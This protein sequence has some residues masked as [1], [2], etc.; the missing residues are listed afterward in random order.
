[1]P[2]GGVAGG[3]YD[4]GAS[5]PRRS[6]LSFSPVDKSSESLSI[7]SVNSED[8]EDFINRTSRQVN[9]FFR[10]VDQDDAVKCQRFPDS[11]ER[12]EAVGVANFFGE[13]EHVSDWKSFADLEKLEKQSPK[14]TKTGGAET[15]AFYLPPVRTGKSKKVIEA[16]YQKARIPETEV[17]QKKKLSRG[18]TFSGKVPESPKTPVIST[19]LALS[20]SDLLQLEAMANSSQVSHIHTRTKKTKKVDEQSSSRKKLPRGVTF[21]GKLPTSSKIGHPDLVAETPDPNGMAS[22]KPQSMRGKGSVPFYQKM[23]KYDKSADINDESGKKEFV[24]RSLPRVKTFDGTNKVIEMPITKESSTQ[25]PRTKLPRAK[26][27]GGKNKE[28]ENSSVSN[29]IQEHPFLAISEVSLASRE[30]IPNRRT[31][32]NTRAPMVGAMTD[33]FGRER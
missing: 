15:D 1:M 30:H 14:A 13:T 5:S 6:R 3:L 33:V 28:T 8:E 24:R 25:Q 29:Q 27:F 2:Y 23:P 4:H 32:V 12:T 7:T 16:T 11:P 22:N 20:P 18:H 9:K 21:G 17:L 26:T 10:K 31:M 19:S